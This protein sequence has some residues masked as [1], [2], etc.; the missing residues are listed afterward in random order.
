MYEQTLYTVLK[1]YINP[2]IGNGIT[3]CKLVIIPNFTDLQLA[4]NQ[5]LHSWVVY[6]LPVE[7]GW[8][9]AEDFPSCIMSQV[10]TPIRVAGGVVGFVRYH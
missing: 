1:D 9:I 10:E 6:Y 8:Y 2:K 5:H 7:V 4:M 3:N